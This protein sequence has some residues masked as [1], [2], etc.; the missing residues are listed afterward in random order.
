MCYLTVTLPLCAAD[1]F[2]APITHD[3]LRAAVRKGRRG[4]APGVDGVSH[5]FFR[6]AWDSIHTDL[7]AIVQ[8]MYTE[9]VTSRDQKLGL[10]V[11]VPKTQAPAV[12]ADYRFLTMLNADVKLLA[13]IIASRLEVW[14]PDI[15]HPSQYCGVRDRTILDAVSAIRDVVAYAE[16]RRQA[17][18]VLSLDFKAAFDRISHTYLFEL[19]E[20][21]G[22]DPHLQHR[23]RSLYLEA[24]ASVSIN[25]CRTSA[26]PIECGVRQGCPLSMALF[27][28]ALNP[29]LSMLAATL[30]G[31]STGRKSAPVAAIAY[32]DDV[33]VFLTSPHDV[34]LLRRALTLYERASGAEV[35]VRKSAALALGSW[36]TATTIWDIPYL[37]DVR[38]LGIHYKASINC[39]AVATWA[40][41]IQGIRARAREAYVRTL[42]LAS[43][44]RFIHT[45]LLAR[46]WYAAQVLPLTVACVRTI[47]TAVT[48][49]LWKG[50]VFRL[51]YSTL[52]RPKLEGGWE[53][54]DVEAKGRALFHA[55]L[56][57][58][59]RMVGTL[60]SAWLGQWTHVSD[61]GNPP[62]VGRIPP[63]L[64]YI[65]QYVQDEAYVLERNAEESKKTYKRRLYR[66]M[67]DLLR[68]SAEPPPMR[69][70]TMWPATRWEV[71]WRNVQMMPGS[72]LVR[73]NWF[74]LIHDLVP[75]NVRLHR[76]ALRDTEQCERCEGTDT[77]P[78]RLTECG[79]GP[80]TW[81][82]TR[83]RIA[84]ILRT[85]QA[86]IPEEWLL[87]PDF[88]IWPPQRHRAVLW[89]LAHMAVF[90]TARELTSLDY[91]DFLRRAR[92][93]ITSVPARKA[94][95]GNYLLTLD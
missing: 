93:K 18:C 33:T 14:L 5:D 10:M 57:T 79:D 66:T 49:F 29:L 1:A 48:M 86:H 63:A 13:R 9:G 26:I 8:H 35:N 24:H 88:Q 7:L 82:W 90:R 78:H 6:E 85:S 92:W 91:H 3:E 46:V 22:F 15:L 80:A 71:V 41:I 17:L 40:P 76:I 12:P 27:A 38:I 45:Y 2:D 44:I 21:Y 95:V 54:M 84:A 52:T 77:L 83:A 42:C 61:G 81:Q 47:R 39:S 28:L 20:R 19:L 74:H 37:Q 53:L 89:I 87:R 32:A 23:I 58:Q 62:D 56:S 72:E 4:K 36:D 51:P 70:A 67:L 60:T 34:P 43:R 50:A 30:P 16:H 59:R 25:G 55:R 65:R 68:D 11:C 73:V 31:V 75:T 64:R 94:L 69:I